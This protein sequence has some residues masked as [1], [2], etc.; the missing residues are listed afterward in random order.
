MALPP[1]S[2]RFDD[3]ADR[4]FREGRRPGDRSQLGPYPSAITDPRDFANAFISKKNNP[5]GDGFWQQV[6]SQDAADASQEKINTAFKFGEPNFPGPMNALAKDFLFK[7]SG[8]GGAIERGLIEQD[9]AVSRDNLARFVQEPAASRIN[10]KDQN[11]AG[12]SQFAGAGGI[13]V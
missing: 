9:R 2:R 1:F 4:A 11:T 10:S 7:Y 3:P 6:F 13:N 12:T 8:P 5:I